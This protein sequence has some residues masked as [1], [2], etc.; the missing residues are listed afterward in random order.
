M[1]LNLNES[2]PLKIKTVRQI[3]PETV[4]R[5]EFDPGTGEYTKIESRS[6]EGFVQ[7]SPPENGSHTA[8]YDGEKL[9][10][11]V[12]LTWN[13]VCVDGQCDDLWDLCNFPGFN[14]KGIEVD[15]T[16]LPDTVIPASI[17]A[18]LG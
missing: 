13:I 9:F 2:V 14:S 4:T 16:D 8:T 3:M 18:L 17:V 15:I 5:F 7:I 10:G 6:E 1:K 11:V 12:M